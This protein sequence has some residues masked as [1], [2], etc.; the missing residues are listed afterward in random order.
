MRQIASEARKGTGTEHTSRVYS[1][2]AE[3]AEPDFQLRHSVLQVPS[4]L[5]VLFRSQSLY[6]QHKAQRSIPR[7]RS[8]WTPSTLTPKPS[9]I[10]REPDPGATREVPTPLVF[11]SVREWE[12]SGDGFDQMS[13]LYSLRGYRSITIDI[14]LSSPSPHPPLAPPRRA[15]PTATQ[16][17]LSPFTGLT[18]ALRASLRLTALAWPPVLL[19]RGMGCLLA[20]AYVSDFPVKALVLLQPPTS[21]RS[22]ADRMRDLGVKPGS[23]EQSREVQEAE[24]EFTYEP[25][26][27]IL[28]VDT[29]PAAEKQRKEN[30]IVRDWGVELL[31]LEG[32]D[33]GDG[34]GV[35]K[36]VTEVERWMDGVGI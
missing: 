4:S 32:L 10:V 29:P 24:W 14:P 17:P 6:S 8:I 31:E 20:Q 7:S 30:R 21:V 28:V 16:K 1:K 27:P 25:R 35:G 5:A 19:A 15:T 9:L 13:A 2:A 3:V 34:D 36:V 11:V 22:V 33:G 12:G 18:Q 23:P 26:F